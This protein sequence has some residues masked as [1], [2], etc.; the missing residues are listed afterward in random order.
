MKTGKNTLVLVLLLQSC[1]LLLITTC[2]VQAQD[3]SFSIT[4]ASHI[5]GGTNCGA[6]SG[7]YAYLGQAQ[8]LSVL[9]IS[10]SPFQ[11]VAYLELPDAPDDIFIAGNYAYLSA[12]GLRIVDISNPLAPTLTGYHALGDSS[13][14]EVYVSGNYAYVA[15]GR[16]G[17]K[18]ADIS[19][20]ASPQLVKT[21]LPE[22]YSNI[23]DVFV[24]GDYAY[25]IDGYRNSVRILDVSDPATPVEKSTFYI[26]NLKKVFVQG[27]YAYV[28]SEASP[29]NYVDLHVVD[30]ANPNAPAEVGYLHAQ[31]TTAG[32]KQPT[33]L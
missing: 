31:V 20:P 33:A 17:L 13:E 23:I 3:D 32:S 27:T 16:S 2:S 30:V 9:D 28:A 25:V 10:A 11:Q 18:I 8:Y 19:N 1:I 6:V 12:A 29:Y 26:L 24:K 21:L 4:P 7:N 5:G 22:N 14:G 15:A